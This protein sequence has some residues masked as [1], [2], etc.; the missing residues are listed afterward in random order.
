MGPLFVL[1][2]WIVIAALFGVV[3]A[4]LVWVGQ[5]AQPRPLRRRRALAAAALPLLLALWI[6]PM[7]GVWFAVGERLGIQVRFPF[8]DAWSVKLPNGYQ[9][10]LIDDFSTARLYSPGAR[11]AAYLSDITKIA[12]DRE[13]VFGLV[14]SVPFVLDTDSQPK[15]VPDFEVLRQRVPLQ[16]VRDFGRSRENPGYELLWWLLWLVPPLALVQRWWRPKS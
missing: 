14:G 2:F 9:L 8:G 11:D 16:S 15:A 5:R 1:A 3:S 4:A 13:V 6:T 7:S 10:G 12:V